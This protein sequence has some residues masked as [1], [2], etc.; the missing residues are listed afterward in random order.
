MLWLPNTDNPAFRAQLKDECQRLAR[1]TVDEE[2][3]ADESEQLAS[4]IEGWQ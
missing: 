3:V 4:G 1:L 2:L